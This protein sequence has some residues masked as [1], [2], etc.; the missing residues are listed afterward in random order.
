[1]TFLNESPAKSKSNEKY[2]LFNKMSCISPWGPLREKNHTLKWVNW[3]ELNEGTLYR[4]IGRIWDT[5][6]E[7]WCIPKLAQ[8]GAMPIPR[9]KRV[10][11]RTG[12]GNGSRK[13]LSNRRWGLL[14]GYTAQ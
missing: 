14:W 5:D 13:E 6:K 10:I 9:L 1:M 7:W 2:N 4:A 3:W 11:M 12:K 8:E